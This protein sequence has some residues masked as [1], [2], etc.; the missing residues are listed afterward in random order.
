M[1]T[2]ADNNA[3][4]MRKGRHKALKGE[5]HPCVKITEEKVIEI[6]DLYKSGG[7]S[8]VSLAKHLGL[9]KGLVSSVLLRQSWKHIT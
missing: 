4:K 3:D 1:G 2:K 8:H 5:G 7:F 9:T 6:R